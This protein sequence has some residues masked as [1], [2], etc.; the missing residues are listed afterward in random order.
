MKIASGWRRICDAAEVE[1]ELLQLGL[2]RD[3]LLRREQ[4]QLT[5]RL[6]AAQVVEITDAVGDRAPVGEQAA[7]PAVRHVRHADPRRLVVHRV[8][9]LLLR[10]DEEN[11]AAALG[12]VACEVVRFLHELLRLLQV[13]DVDAATLGEDE[14]LHLR[15]PASR[16]VAEVNSASSSSFMETTANGTSPFRDGLHCTAP[17]GLSGTGPD[18]RSHVQSRRA[19]APPPGR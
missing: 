4:G 10:A 6:E 13:D 15:V 14:T 2:H 1:L 5:L 12:H 7:E 9:R 19:A 16:L 3:P 17:A 11:R 8:L 18:P